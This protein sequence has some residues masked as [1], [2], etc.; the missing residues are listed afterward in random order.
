MKARS[1]QRGSARST[2]VNL[3][4]ILLVIL[5]CTVAGIWGAI[6]LHTSIFPPAPDVTMPAFPEGFTFILLFGLGLILGGLIGGFIWA[7]IAKQFMTRDEVYQHANFGVRIPVVTSIN[8]AYLR[9]IFRNEGK[10]R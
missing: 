1:G 4:L 3:L 9:W 5:P 8:K 2:I 7:A 6:K 10:R